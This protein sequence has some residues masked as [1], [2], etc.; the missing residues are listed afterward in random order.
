MTPDPEPH[1]RREVT[2]AQLLPNMLTVAAICAGVT[3][4]RLGVQGDYVRAVQLLRWL[5]RRRRIGT[6]TSSRVPVPAFRRIAA[7]LADPFSTGS[8]RTPP[9][10]SRHSRPRFCGQRCLVF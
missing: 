4:I 3:A 2:L 10:R 9:L 6:T 5:S 8:T 1:A 7:A